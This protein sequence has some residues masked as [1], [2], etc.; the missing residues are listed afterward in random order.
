[1]YVLKNKI[2]SI[3]GAI[4]PFINKELAVVNIFG[5]LVSGS[6]TCFTCFTELHAGHCISFIFKKDTTQYF[7][8]MY[9]LL[10]FLLSPS[11]HITLFNNSVSTT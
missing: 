8:H 5:L 4:G 1:M 6:Q 2:R 7:F 3:S 11:L 9:K 10:L